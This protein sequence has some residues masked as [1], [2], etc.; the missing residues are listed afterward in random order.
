MQTRRRARRRGRSLLAQLAAAAMLAC[1]GAAGAMFDDPPNAGPSDE[2]ADTR[3]AGCPGRAAYEA[4]ASH[5]ATTSQAMMD[6]GF[7]AHDPA[8]TL[9]RF[10]IVPYGVLWGYAERAAPPPAP[11]GAA[12]PDYRAALYHMTECPQAPD[13]DHFL[14]LDHLITL[15]GHEGLKLYRSADVTMESGP[16]GI[17]AADDVV[18]VKINYQWAER[19]GTNV[20]LLRG[21]LRRL[22]DHPNGFTGE[23]AVCENAQ[24]ASV[25]DFDRTTN[26]AEDIGL[27]P[28]DVVNQLQIE[29]VRIS[30]FDWT[31]MRYVDV[32]EYAD[33][34]T[35][36]GYVISPYDP[37]LNGKVS[38]PKFRTE[39]GTHVSLKRGLWDPQSATYDRARLK[40]V[41]LPV[42]KSHHAVYGVTAS[43][44]NYMG[45]VTRELGTNSHAAIAR[46]IMGAVIGEIEP[47]DL[48]ILDCTWI[49]AN[50]YGGPWTTY[51]EATRRDELVASRDPV[52]LDVWAARNILI[53]AFIANGYG[54][55][56]PEPSADP[57]DPS[58][59]FRRYLD[60]SMQYILAA[61]H[62]VTNDDDRTD[63]VTWSG[64]GD[65]DGDGENDDDDN[66]PYDANPGQEDCDEDGVG[67][68]CEIREGLSDDRNG[69]GVPDGCEC[70][71]D[72][73]ESG[74]VEFADVIT[75]LGAWGPCEG[76][77][78]DLDADDI[79]AFSDVLI[80]LLGWGPCP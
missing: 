73:D 39:Y 9:V 30:L 54:P 1:G 22:A 29:G 79:V 65:L 27:S 53:P 52:A 19:G 67:D 7:P 58:S 37:A 2:G 38:Y 48:N 71:G 25:Q 13:G 74:A 59:D 68:V 64:G 6:H 36:D 57:D 80:V 33:G 61:G 8:P 4:G 24:F 42:L 12:S 62:D 21:L 45:V 14:G 5:E 66:C 40:F 55:P 17:I 34:D 56:W 69:N 72:I 63:V 35:I 18:V 20:D 11:A 15:M 70:L 75:L 23:I 60:N 50:P 44:K 47:A 49:N 46:G 51:G 31:S 3:P 16:D 41:N 43:V 28:R 32:D 77:P 10:R 76:C 26:N 78:E